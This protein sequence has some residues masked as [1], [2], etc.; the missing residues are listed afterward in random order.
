[1]IT[2]VTIGLIA[3]FYRG[4][5]DEVLMRLADI[6]LAFPGILLA[7]ALMAVLGPGLGN[8]VMA[9]VTIGWISYARLA[10]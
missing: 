7:I 1:M 3:G 6:F 8:V 2:G 5:L 9:L 10:R 4:W